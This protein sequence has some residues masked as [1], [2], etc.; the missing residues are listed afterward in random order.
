MRDRSAT[1]PDA[2]E[3]QQ[4]AKSRL[5]ESSAALAKDQAQIQDMSAGAAKLNNFLEWHRD[6]HVERQSASANELAIQ[7]IQ[8]AFSFI[9]VSKIDQDIIASFTLECSLVAQQNANRVVVLEI[10]V[11]KPTARDT[12]RLAKMIGVASTM[13]KVLGIEGV[14]LMWLPDVQKEQGSQSLDDEEKDSCSL[15]VCRQQMHRCVKAIL[16]PQLRVLIRQLLL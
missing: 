10:D 16:Q 12:A 2:G 13:L 3:A 14:L 5:L 15:S 9:K 4:V 6:Q 7:Y 11:N 1:R 8:K